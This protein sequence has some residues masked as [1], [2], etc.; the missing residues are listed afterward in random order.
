MPVSRN[1]FARSDCRTSNRPGRRTGS[2]C[3]R[4]KRQRC[5]LLV[6]A[7]ALEFRQIPPDHGCVRMIRPERSLANGQR[8]PVERFRLGVVMLDMIDCGEVVQDG[9]QLR[10]IALE[11]SLTYFKRASE[12]VAGIGIAMQVEID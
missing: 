7:S 11:R 10:M 3:L 1:C 4:N 6:A 2:G 12:L 8:A 9:S 5:G